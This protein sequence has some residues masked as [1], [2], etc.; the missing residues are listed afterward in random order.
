M[1][2]SAVV[3][4]LL[5]LLVGCRHS[6]DGELVLPYNHPASPTAQSAPPIRVPPIQGPDPAPVVPD[7]GEVGAVP[8]SNAKSSPQQYHH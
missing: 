6:Q 7:V 3:F 1:I 2:R 4:L 5:S 8:A